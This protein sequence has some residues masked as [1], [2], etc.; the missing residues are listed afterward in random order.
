MIKEIFDTIASISAKNDKI[1]ELKMHGD[2]DVLKRAIYLAQ[3]PRVNF[4]IKQI[5]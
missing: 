2:N 3:S 1:A 4:Y 5:P